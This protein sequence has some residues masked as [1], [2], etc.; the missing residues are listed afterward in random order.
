MCV[1]VYVC[2]HAGVSV[3]VPMCSAAP[4]GSGTMIALHVGSRELS[5]LPPTLVDPPVLS[6]VLSNLGLVKRYGLWSGGGVSVGSILRFYFYSHLLKECER[7]L[8][9]TTLMCKL[10]KALLASRPHVNAQPS[11]QTGQIQPSLDP[12]TSHPQ[13]ISY[14]DYI[15]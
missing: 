7:G 8:S 10:E 13:G 1:C 14:L 5:P 9:D 3:S 12:S 4:L 2:V 11:K 6:C 15:S